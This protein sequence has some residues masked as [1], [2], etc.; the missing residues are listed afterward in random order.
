[1][2]VRS[3]TSVPMSAAVFDIE[4]TDF[5]AGGI[6]DHMI[7][8]SI[9]PLEGKIETYKISHSDNR[10]DCRVLTEFLGA[11][12]RYGLLIGHNILAFDILWLRSRSS[13][14]G[15]ELPER[16]YIC[17]DTYQA[18]RR[19][20]IKAERK[21]LA[22]LG[23]FYRLKNLKTLIYP[24]AWSMVD[25]PGRTEA[26]EAITSVVSHCE[27]DVT[28]NRDLFYALWQRDKM[29]SLPIRRM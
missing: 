27:Q 29:V 21:S 2:K 4:T 24:V 23:D 22:F 9:L 25:S 8:G 14:H 6:L 5:A 10:D 28:M 13:Y 1:M 3:Y 19:Q 18:A 16:Q 7:C 17:Y 26:E 20:G 12:S 15:L 11:L